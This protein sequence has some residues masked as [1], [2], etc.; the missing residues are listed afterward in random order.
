MSHCSW[1]AIELNIVNQEGDTIFQYIRGACISKNGV[2]KEAKMLE[3]IE[4][5]LHEAIKYLFLRYC[6]ISSS[7]ILFSTNLIIMFYFSVRYSVLIQ[8][9]CLNPNK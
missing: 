5:Y 1:V 8:F 3:T 2:G 9:N 7:I 6:K 4:I